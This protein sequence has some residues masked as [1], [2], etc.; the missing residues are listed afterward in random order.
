MKST[1]K[2]NVSKRRTVSVSI[3]TVLQSLTTETKDAVQAMNRVA[4]SRLRQ[5]PYILPTLSYIGLSD[6]DSD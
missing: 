3:D 6:A 5:K 1:S 2:R 4:T